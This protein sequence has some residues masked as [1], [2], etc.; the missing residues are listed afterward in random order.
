MVKL[1]VNI[2]KEEKDKLIQ[3][4]K[5]RNEVFTSK[6]VDMLR[7]DLMVTYHKLAIDPKVKLV[8]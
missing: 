5:E 1:E 2:V 6:P 8:K 3:L 4:L 7:I